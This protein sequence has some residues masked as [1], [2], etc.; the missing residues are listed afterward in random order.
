MRTS[1]GLAVCGLLLSLMACSDADTLGDEPPIEIAIGA[2]PTYQNGVG[3]L[4]KVKCGTCH[5]HP[6]TELSPDNIVTDLDLNTYLTRVEAG[7]VIRG[8]DSIGRWI[9]EGI[10]DH[11]VDRF[12]DTSEPR[13]MPLDY[14]TPVT[15]S[16]KQALLAWSA[17]GSPFSPDDTLP[18]GNADNGANNYF[19]YCTECHDLGNGAALEDKWFGPGIRPSA[20]TLAKVKSMWLHKAQP[21]PLS[22]G[23][24]ADLAAFILGLPSLEAE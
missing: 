13:K 6:L 7:E 15:P 3:E 20:V 19:T 2:E 23:D 9:F 12:L 21:E 18:D 8:A 4:L 10:L 5:A 24:A 1:Y 17:S 11:G 14:A 16:E 22:D